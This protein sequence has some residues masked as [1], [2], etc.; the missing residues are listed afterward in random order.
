M[1]TVQ[2]RIKRFG[3]SAV[4]V[5]HEDKF[6]EAQKDARFQQHVLGEAFFEKRNRK[7]DEG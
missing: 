6:E 1:D 5:S 3:Q 7:Q 4:L 2:A